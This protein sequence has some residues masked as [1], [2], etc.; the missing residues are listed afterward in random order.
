M[1]NFELRHLTQAD[2][3]LHVWRYLTFPK[4]VSM[5]VYSAL[6]F[7][8]LKTLLSMDADEGAMPAVAA[9]EMTERFLQ[10]D[11]IKN[12]PSFTERIKNS[13]SRNVED[14]RELTL[15]NCWFCSE[16]ES[17]AMWRDYAGIPEGVA[18]VST[19]DLLSQ[20]VYCDP[21]VSLIGRVQYVNLTSHVMSHYEA[22]QA[23]ERAF[24]KGNG[25][26]AEREI[27]M[28]TMSFRGPMCVNLDGTDMRPDQY[29]GLGMN[30]F[31]SP[32]LYIKA[33]L[34]KLITRTVLSPD[35][36]VFLEHLVRR[37][38]HLAGVVSPVERSSLE[39]R[40]V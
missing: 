11:M 22:N 15:A 17:P 4:Y 21:R 10:W 38:G 29:S 14:G 8:K 40:P 27:R 16:E 32:G 25:F 1:A 6:W 20:Y 23:G 7:P 12:N 37:I 9:R 31:D 34:R 39:N 19:I 36:P 13:S 2:L 26:A 18:V 28:T 24:L 5:M 33:D 30:N 3:N 35:A